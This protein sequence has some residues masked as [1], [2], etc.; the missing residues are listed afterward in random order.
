MP[1][2]HALGIAHCYF[3]LHSQ[4]VAWATAM[5]MPLRSY[6]RPEVPSP[7]GQNGTRSIRKSKFAEV[8]Y[9]EGYNWGLT[10]LKE[11]I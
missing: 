6:K 1:R 2:V 7:E 11:K 3:A 5:T 10:L 8:H 4:R 9:P